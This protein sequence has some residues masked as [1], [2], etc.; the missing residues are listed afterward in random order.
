MTGHNIVLLFGA[1]LVL[2]IVPGPS[3]FAV[4]ARTTTSGFAHGLLLIGGIIVADFLFILL[5]VYSLAAVADALG[6]LFVLVQYVCGAYLI[7]LGL[8]ALRTRPRPVA[9]SETGGYSGVSSFLSGL[10]I[11]LGDPK[12]ILFYMGLLPAFVNV[13]DVSLTDTITVMIIAT[14]AIGGV[15]TAY[16]YLADR[17]RSVF[18]NAAAQRWLNIAA[19]IVLVGTGVNLFWRAG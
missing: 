15:K 6:G 8:N 1:M 5:A 9:A 16:A 18:S 13:S 2:T 14:V 7:W 11:T 4:V 17:A 19:G 10:L 12:A 3:D